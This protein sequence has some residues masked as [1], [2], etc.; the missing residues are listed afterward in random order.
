MDFSD[1]PWVWPP[2]G[3][4]PFDRNGTTPVA[5]A[6]QADV[7]SVAL[8]VGM[9]GWMVEAGIE[10]S[11]YGTVGAPAFWQLLLDGQIIRDYGMVRVPIGAPATPARLYVKL[12]Q[13]QTL[14]LRV[15]NNSG[16]QIAARWRLYGWYYPKAF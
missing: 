16:V 4:L 12:A 2:A 13:S 14:T 9:E 15:V 10:L 6:T 11:G 5:N 7:E 8:Q 3:F 1:Y